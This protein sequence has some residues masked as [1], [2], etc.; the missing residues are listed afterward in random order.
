ME[1]MKVVNGAGK[2][3]PIERVEQETSG[4]LPQA[5][6][7]IKNGTPEKSDR[8]KSI[9]K[10]KW[11]CVCNKEHKKILFKISYCVYCQAYYEKRG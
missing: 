9:C 6:T 11:D 8:G 7:I 1:G 4:K 10:L 2:V 3:L 5:D